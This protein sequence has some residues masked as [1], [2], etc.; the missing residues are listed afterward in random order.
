MAIMRIDHWILEL[1]A[2]VLKIAWKHVAISLENI[3]IYVVIHF[4]YNYGAQR[5]SVDIT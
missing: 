4:G 1:F 3:K 5:F 2:L